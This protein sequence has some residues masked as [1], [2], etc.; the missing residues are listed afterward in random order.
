MYIYM[1]N[2]TMHLLSSVTPTWSRDNP[3]FHCE[4]LVLVWFWTP[5]S[6]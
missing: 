5:L 1:K 6:G 4:R 2:K 3:F